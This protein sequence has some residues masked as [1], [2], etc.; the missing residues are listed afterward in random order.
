MS[1]KM[2]GV[3]GNIHPYSMP[4]QLAQVK[5]GYK[6]WEKYKF[7]KLKLNETAEHG[8]VVDPYLH[9]VIVVTIYPLAHR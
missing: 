8:P 1:E 3:F 7:L 4:L 5:S 6:Q 2:R 9:I